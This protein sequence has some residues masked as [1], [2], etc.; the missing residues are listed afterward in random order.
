MK[1]EGLFLRT[2]HSCGIVEGA[3]EALLR[4]PGCQRLGS[5][6][7]CCH[8][9][10]PS[11]KSGDILPVTVPKRNPVA[12]HLLF[13]SRS[14][15]H[16]KVRPL[17][18]SSPLGGWTSVRPRKPTDCRLAQRVISSGK[19]NFQLGEGTRKKRAF[20]SH[21]SWLDRVCLTSHVTRQKDI[22]L[23]VRSVLPHLVELFGGHRDSWDIESAQ[24]EP[25]Y[26]P[27]RPSILLH[28]LRVETTAPAVVSNTGTTLM[29][30]AIAECMTFKSASSRASLCFSAFAVDRNVLH[31]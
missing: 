9:F 10:H 14:S 7:F 18:Q 27:E 12:T 15:H 19:Q 5:G 26:L 8:V 25:Q 20:N 13:F 2:T 17:L 4:F 22:E 11:W 30:S 16:H 31:Q 1:G 3:P 21:V 24:A 6:C 28:H 29:S 23:C